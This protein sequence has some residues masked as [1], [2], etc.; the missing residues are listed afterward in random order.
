MLY[1]AKISFFS[2]TISKE[3][4]ERDSNLKTEKNYLSRLD[5]N[6]LFTWNFVARNPPGGTPLPQK[7]MQDPV[8]HLLISFVASLDIL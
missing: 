6:V 5:K 4:Q 8:M 7:K 3:K 2:V 1:V